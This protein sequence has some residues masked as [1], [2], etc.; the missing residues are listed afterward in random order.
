MFEPFYTTKEIGRGSGLG[1]AQVHGFARMSGGSVRIDSTVG[2]GTT[3]SLLLPRS[4]R[5]PTSAPHPPARV[6]R[7]AQRTSGSVLLVE[8]DDEVAALVTDM[9]E[10]LGYEV[11]RTASAAAALGALSNGRAIDLVFSDIMMPG[12]MN[13]VELAREVRHRRRGL[14]ILLTS[15]HAEAASASAEG[16]RILA[17]PYR[18]EE[19]AT[20]LE[21]AIT[22]C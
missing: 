6:A 19:L 16:V 1:L 8:D 22:R 3:V 12:G 15:G 2:V 10:E 20:A 9:L 14:P 7:G 5:T 11:T 4:H 17:K 18:L 21:T 13:G